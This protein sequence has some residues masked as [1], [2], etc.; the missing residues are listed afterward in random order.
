MFACVTQKSKVQLNQTLKN[1]RGCAKHDAPGK[2]VVFEALLSDV[3]GSLDITVVHVPSGQHMTLHPQDRTVTLNRSNDTV[4]VL[5]DETND[6][7]N[8]N[9][10]SGQVCFTSGD[11]ARLFATADVSG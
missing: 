8:I 7:V 6:G 11:R 9:L 2:K 5:C 4:R 3:M 1:F 10:K